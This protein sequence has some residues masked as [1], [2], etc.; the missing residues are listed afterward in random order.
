[1]LWYEKYLVVSLIFSFLTHD[2]YSRSRRE[3]YIFA[4]IKM[5]DTR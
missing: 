4:E 1:M 5:F 3:W 2:A